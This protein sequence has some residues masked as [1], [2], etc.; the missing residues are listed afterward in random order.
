MVKPPELRKI[1]GDVSNRTVR[2][3]MGVLIDKGLI[4]QEGSTKS[5][6]YRYLGK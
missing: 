3:D 4:S 5:T 1:A 2:R 6:Y